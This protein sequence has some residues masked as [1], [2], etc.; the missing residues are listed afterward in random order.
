MVPEGRPLNEITL[1]NQVEIQ[2]YVLRVIAITKT[3]K[4]SVFGKDGPSAKKFCEERGRPMPAGV[5]PNQ[6]WATKRKRTWI[7][8]NLLAENPTEDAKKWYKSEY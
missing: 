5:K 3:W 8:D 1:R 4:E 6:K 2:V 7:V